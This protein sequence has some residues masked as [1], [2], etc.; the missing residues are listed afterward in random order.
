MGPSES[1]VIFDNPMRLFLITPLCG[2]AGIR[3]TLR[4]LLPIPETTNPNKAKPPGAH[5]GGFALW[6]CRESNPGPT[7]QIWD[8]SERSRRDVFST[9]PLFTTPRE[10]RSKLLKRFS[11]DPRSPN[12]WLVPWRRPTVRGPF[13]PNASPIAVR[14]RGRSWCFSVWHL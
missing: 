10:T 9:F 8:F 6:R 5:P 12:H 11:A 7:V 3:R 13:P 2:G 14:Q 4:A 1:G